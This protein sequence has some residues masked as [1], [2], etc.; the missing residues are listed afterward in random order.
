MLKVKRE[1]KEA[2]KLKGKVMPVDAPAFRASV[3]VHVAAT[4]LAGDL[5]N[6]LT[7]HKTNLQSSATEAAKHGVQGIA[8]M[9]DWLLG[10]GNPR[11][12]CPNAWSGVKSHKQKENKNKKKMTKKEKEQ[13]T[14]IRKSKKAL[15]KI[16]REISATV[17][18]R[19]PHRGP[20]G[21]RVD[22]FAPSLG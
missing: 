13:Q 18:P 15:R 8:D 20:G 1:L 5:Q 17:N 11:H 12:V 19:P 3:E 10:A 6:W 21:A 16:K 9:R 2:C 14:K 22:P 4:P 7:L